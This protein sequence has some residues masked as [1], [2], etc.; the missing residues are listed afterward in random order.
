[1]SKHIEAEGGELL[2]KSSNG[3]MA[4]VPKNMA[5]FIKEHI[6]SGNHAA[7]D[8]Y[9]KGLQEMKDG[10]KAQDGGTIKPPSNA[11]AS[12]ALQVNRFPIPPETDA[13]KPIVQPAPFGAYPVRVLKYANKLLGGHISEGGNPNETYSDV[14]YR[15]SKTPGT[16]Q[17]RLFSEEQNRANGAVGDVLYNPINLAPV[18]GW[19][20][21]GLQGL[22]AAQQVSKAAKTFN[23][24]AQMAKPTALMSDV[25]EGVESYNDYTKKPPIKDLTEEQQK[26]MTDMINNL[27]KSKG[28]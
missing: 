19:A 25:A 20:A 9:V 8:H 24:M 28:K 1:M 5:E 17:N 15:L 2:I 12:D 27:N 10:S 26:F 21:K 6:K 16:I 23:R 22:A 13:R 11:V 7:V 18:G 4:I 3:Y 14:T